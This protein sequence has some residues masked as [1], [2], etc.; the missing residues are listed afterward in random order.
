M[1]HVELN[2]DQTNRFFLKN[3]KRYDTIISRFSVLFEKM[4][5]NVNPR[6][7]ETL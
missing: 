6:P 3:L 2:F 1:K 5:Y 4:S 7:L